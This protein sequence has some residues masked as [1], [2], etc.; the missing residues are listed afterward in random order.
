MHILVNVWFFIILV[1]NS[2]FYYVL[3]Q[4]PGI[5]GSLSFTEE[6]PIRLPDRDINDVYV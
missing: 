6:N 3:F 5:P 1:K 2:I 4:Y